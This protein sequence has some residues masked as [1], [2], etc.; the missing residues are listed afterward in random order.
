MSDD[1]KVRKI[2]TCTRRVLS[3]LQDMTGV[4]TVPQLV[5]CFKVRQ[6]T[7]EDSVGGLFQRTCHY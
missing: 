4:R 1:A 5:V 6:S 3:H 2:V 7:Y